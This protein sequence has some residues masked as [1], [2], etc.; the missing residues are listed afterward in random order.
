M[1]FMAA[2]GYNLESGLNPSYK[3]SAYAKEQVIFNKP[4]SKLKNLK[5]V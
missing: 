1:G 5:E 4:L 3:S 2:L